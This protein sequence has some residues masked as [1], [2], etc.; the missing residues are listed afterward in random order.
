MKIYKKAGAVAIAAAI[1]F[2]APY[3]DAEQGEK[4][5]QEQGTGAN[6]AVSPSTVRQ[7]QKKLNS[8]GFDSGHVDGTWGNKTQ[9]AVKNFQQAQG[10]EATGRLD[11]ET[12]SALGVSAGGGSAAGGDTEKSKKKSDQKKSDDSSMKSGGTGGSTQQDSESDM[13]SGAGTGG[14]TQ[15]DSESDMK[16]GTDAGGSIQQQDSGSD[17]KS[18]GGTGGSS[19][20]GGKQY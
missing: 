19:Q 18:G 20:Q 7:V 15:Q 17:M 4:L 14:S 2:G 10:M 1:G 12:L 13:K 9:Q 16:S 5:T 8:K 11:K 3:A 6:M